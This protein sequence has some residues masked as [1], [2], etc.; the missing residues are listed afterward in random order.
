MYSEGDVLLLVNC[1]KGK[2]LPRIEGGEP[3]NRNEQTDARHRNGRISVAQK[4]GGR[5]GKT[6]LIRAMWLVVLTDGE[7]CN[8]CLGT[9]VPKG[10]RPY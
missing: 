6:Q 10:E 7:T 3:T 8:H 5:L 2:A 9:C 4:E 1:L